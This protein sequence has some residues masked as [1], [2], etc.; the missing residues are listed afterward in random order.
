MEKD[1]YCMPLIC[2]ILKILKKNK[3]IWQKYREQSSGYQWGG[4]DNI[5]VGENGRYKLLGRRWAEGC[6]VNMGNTSNIL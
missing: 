2:E 5:G 6:I 4:R 3:W 1:Q